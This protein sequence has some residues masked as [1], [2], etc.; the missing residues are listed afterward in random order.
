MQIFLTKQ[1]PEHLSIFWSFISESWPGAS[2]NKWP[3]TRIKLLKTK[4]QMPCPHQSLKL[5]WIKTKGREPNGKLTCLPSGHDDPGSGICRF[6]FIISRRF[7]PLPSLQNQAAVFYLHYLAKIP[8]LCRTK[9]PLSRSAIEMFSSQSKLQGFYHLPSVI[10]LFYLFICFKC[11]FFF[12]F[13]Y[14]QCCC[15]CIF[16]LFLFSGSPSYVSWL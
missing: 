4:E 8:P 7:P 3:G 9:Q 15:C 11:Q 16:I 13:K 2:A 5:N 14:L 10:S 12:F 1:K 6:I